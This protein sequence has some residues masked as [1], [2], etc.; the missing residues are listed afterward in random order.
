MIEARFL[1]RSVLTQVC[2]LGA[3]LGAVLPPQADAAATPIPIDRIVAIVNKGVITERQLNERVDSVMANL[4]HQ[5]VAAPPAEVLRAQVLD[6]MVIEDV[7]LQFAS[8]TGIRIDDTQLN[9]AVA[10]IAEQNKLSVD[11]LKAALEKDG[12]TYAGFRADIRREMTLQRLRDREVDSKVQVSDAEVDN[13][14]SL[15]AA[16]QDAEYMLSNIV[17]GIPEQAS[18][19]VVRD[20]EKR[21]NEALAQLKAGKPFAEVAAAYSTASNA[22]SG[23]QLGWRKANRLPELYVEA[24]S[25]LDKGQL[26]GLLKTANGFHIIQLQDKRAGNQALM[27]EQTHARHILIRT[28]EAVSESDAKAR[29]MQVKE[30]LDNGGKFEELARLYSEDSTGNNGG[31]LGWLSPGDTVPEFEQ[32]MNALKPG[33]TSEPVRT[34]FGWHLIQVTE[35]RQQDV[36]NDKARFEARQ[37]LRER[38][39]DEQYDD[40]VRQLRDQAYV[41]LRLDDQ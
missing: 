14:L 27:I 1:A 23:G 28:N 40:W 12:M 9:A 11:E 22:L 19:E 20:K 3:L 10:R 38:K 33:Q 37:A 29:L 17:V 41:E 39:S 2:L 35:R 4:K 30:R 31:D 13:Y 5:N 7:Q 18:P 24:A 25:K 21:A 6:R 32:A 15:N 8:S 26:S 34:Q 16:N 36:S